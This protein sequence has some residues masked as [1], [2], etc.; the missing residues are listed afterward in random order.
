[1]PEHVFS[2][3]L[4]GKPKSIIWNT[5]VRQGK[6]VSKGHYEATCLYCN[7]FWHKGSP[8]SI[9]A[10]FANE[11]LKVPIEVKRLFLNRL[12]SKAENTTNNSQ[13]KSNRKRKFNDILDDQSKITDF[14]ESSK[15]SQERIHE[16]NRACIKAFAICG[17]PWHI[18]ENPFF[19]EFLKTL[20]PGYTPPSKEILSNHLLAQET[21]VVNRQIIQELE[22]STNLTLCK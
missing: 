12:A 8:Q 14:H 19:I 2:K 22:N 16:I 3:N 18:I 6:E 10:H 17:I 4:G 7:T 13:Q 9:E 20:R 15:L 1:M 11:C 21:A 5:Y